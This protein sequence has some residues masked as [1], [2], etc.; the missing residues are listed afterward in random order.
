M[1]TAIDLETILAPLAGDSPVGEDL[2]Y[3]SVY[4]E[5][6]EARRADDLLDRG[7]WQRDIKTSDWYT[8]IKIASEALSTKSKDLQIAVWLTEA[9]LNTDGFAGLLAGLRI[10]NGFLQDYWE[11]V[12]PV[13]EDDDLDFR[14]ACFEFINDKFG[15]Y[16]AQI[17]VTDPTATNGY[18]FIKWQESRSVGYEADTH[19]RYGSTDYGKAAAREEKIA[20]GKMTAEDFDAAVALTS[21][22][23]YESLR[24]DLALSQE[25]AKKLDGL[26]DEKFGSQ[27]P[28][29][30]QFLGAIEEC[31][32]FVT[33]AIKDKGGREPVRKPAAEQPSQA[34]LESE[35]QPKKG[36]IAR[37]F[38]RHQETAPGTVPEEGEE[39]TQPEAMNDVRTPGPFSDS[40]R[41]ETARWD[42]AL[43]VLETDGIGAALEKLLSASCSAPSV[44]E[45][46]RY[47]LLMAKL[48]LEAD[49]PDLARPIAEELHALIEELHLDRWE[50][51]LWI[52]EVLD[53]LY[54]CLTRGEP[55]DDDTGR[56]AE[57]FQ[58]LCTTDITKAMIYRL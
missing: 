45:R 25:E 46:T 4:D 29:L 35:E 17:P 22:A 9:L 41:L 34:P 52:A 7:D 37:L 2:R 32:R 43:A 24:A 36:Y 55:T 15:V 11:H 27:A 33:R 1:K 57:L 51:P 54:Q 39:M 44:R 20:E 5:I 31:G 6:K 49:R 56:A 14:A 19:D 53:A 13:I 23:W 3:T 42:E 47:R 30:A 18:S 8:V 12:Y 16:V 21:L 58:R 26:L 48:C 28:S 10:L 40:R 38:N 50:S